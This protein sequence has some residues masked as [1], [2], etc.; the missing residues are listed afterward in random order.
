MRQNLWIARL[1]ACL[2]EWGD[3]PEMA[4]KLRK[5]E[6]KT[7]DDKPKDFQALDKNIINA[8]KDLLSETILKKSP[9]LQRIFFAHNE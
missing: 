1:H 2:V 9:S 6:L 4:E 7:K 8:T 5:Y 3:L